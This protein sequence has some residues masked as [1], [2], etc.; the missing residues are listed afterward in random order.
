MKNYELVLIPLI[1]LVSA[2][3]L[4]FIIESISTRKLNWG[5]LFNGSGGMPSSHT[6]LVFSLT[7]IMG[8]HYGISSSYFAI[9]LVFSLVVSYD[10]CGL[11]LESGKQAAAIN[12]L[13]NE[14]IQGD[15]KK[16]YHKLKEELGHN[17]IEVLC[18]IIYGSTIAYFLHVLF[19][20]L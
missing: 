11:R 12:Q 7:T 1:S 10:A 4:K 20:L 3:V 8:I 19:H 14:L 9:S 16:A 6:T 17:P 5:R 2:Q 18:G 13:F 15:K